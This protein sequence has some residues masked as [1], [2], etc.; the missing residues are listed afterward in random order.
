MRV[1]VY[2]CARACVLCVC[3][4][5]CGPVCVCLC[6]VYACVLVAPCVCVCV[7]CVYACVLV[8]PCV[9]MCVCARARVQVSVYALYNQ[10]HAYLLLAVPASSI[11][12]DAN[13][14]R[15]LNLQARYPAN[16]RGFYAAR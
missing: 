3:V 8:A 16:H 11:G 15:K 5:A 9:C 4:R 10:S 14:E 1:C 12:R 6:C 7:C 2:V 13:V